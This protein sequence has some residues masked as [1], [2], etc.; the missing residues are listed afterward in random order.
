MT[1]YYDGKW[2]DVKVASSKD[3]NFDATPFSSEIVYSVSQ[4]GGDYIPTKD[5]FDA[6]SSGTKPI[7]I[8]QAINAANFNYYIR[9]KDVDKVRE[10]FKADKKAVSTKF[11]PKDPE[12]LVVILSAPSL[13]PTVRTYEAA[14]ELSNSNDADYISCTYV[15]QIFGVNYA[16]MRISG[17]VVAGIGV[18]GSMFVYGRRA[19][20]KE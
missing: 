17:F 8:L 12:D 19:I 2:N 5:D 11:S 13:T 16:A 14:F 20:K 10:I 7:V 3:D 6:L 15:K 18:L 1:Q 4:T 9:N